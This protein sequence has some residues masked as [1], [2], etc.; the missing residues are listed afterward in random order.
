MKPQIQNSLK[1]IFL[2]VF[3]QCITLGASAQEG[4][5]VYT[6][7]DSKGNC[8]FYC[9]N[10][11]YCDYTVEVYFSELVNYNWQVQLP[12]QGVVNHGRNFLFSLDAGDP[13]KQSSFLYG[14]T[15]YKGCNNPKINQNFSYLLP[16]SA[17]QTTEPIVL[18]Y[19][20]IN[21]ND[22][23]PKGYYAL[24]FM[25]NAGDTIFA[26]RRGVVSELRDTSSLALS[27]Y[28]YSSDDNYMEIFHKDC[29][30]GRYEVFKESLVSLGQHVEAGDPIAIAGGENYT[31][32][33]HVRFFVIYVDQKLDKNT[34][35]RT[36]SWAYVHLFFCTAENENAP[37]IYDRKYTC[38]KPESVIT[39][40]FSKRELKKWGK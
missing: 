9:T 37:L 26:A 17:G 34:S 4:I 2:L 18:E 11:N 25:L 12:Y 8:K 36:N 29:T 32:G 35:E 40:E 13:V 7:T 16:I 5:N 6:T 1:A 22:R 23:A 31:S 27:D 30:F 24:G 10:E 3:F 38:V 28:V 33:S 21:E 39:Q 19:L 20:K 15:S 14:T